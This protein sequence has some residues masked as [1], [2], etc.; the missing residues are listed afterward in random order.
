MRFSAS[1][2][3]KLVEKF[4]SD[5]SPTILSVVGVA[6]T[7]GTAVLSG[8]AS[9]R[10]RGRLENEDPR[11]PVR[12]KAKRVWKLYIPTVSVGGTTVACIVGSNVISVKRGAA[13]ATVVSLS[14]AAFKEYRAKVV[15]HIGSAKEQRVRD[16][17]AQDRVSRNPASSSQVITLGDSSVLCY[18]TMTGRYFNC[19]METLRRAENTINAQIIRHDYAS[20][21]EFFQ[22]IGLPPTKAGEEIGWNSMNLLELE[23]S[24]VLSEDGKPCLSVGYYTVP[25]RDYYR[26]P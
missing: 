5:N 15:E 24:S 1:K 20:Q 25:I 18:E 23:F 26:F 10:A 12:E 13:L 2:T 11:M 14:E 3:L 17:I 9:W 19:D 7:I 21:N 8:R 16:E 4:L 22:E 6:G